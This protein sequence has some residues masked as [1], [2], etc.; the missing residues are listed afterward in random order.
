MNNTRA[1]ARLNEKE[2]Q[3]LTGHSA[4]WHDQYRHSA[5]IY[6][7]GLPKEMTEGDILTVFSQLRRL[8]LHAS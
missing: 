5:Y 7:G 1:I 6:I 2:L 8:S 3:T 4:S